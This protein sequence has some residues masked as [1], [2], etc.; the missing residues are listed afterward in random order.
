MKKIK[1]LTEHIN[2]E[3]CDAQHYAE[4]YVEKKVNG[5]TSM[6][7]KYKEMATD[8][9]K[10]ATYLHDYAMDEIK[11]VQAAGIKVPAE[12]M[13]KWENEHRKYVDKVAWVK[14]ML[15]L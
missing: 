1:D 13:E 5:E 7:S 6:A 10:H 14:Q 2:D 8:E 9:L 4:D 12:M 15:A 3:I 11:K